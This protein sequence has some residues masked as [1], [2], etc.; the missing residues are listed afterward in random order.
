MAE[1]LKPRAAD[2]LLR[3]IIGSHHHHIIG[4]TIYLER[5]S[6][7][8]RIGPAKHPAT[9]YAAATLN[10]HTF[11]LNSESFSEGEGDEGSSDADRGAGTTE[12]GPDEDGYLHLITTAGVHP[13]DDDFFPSIPHGHLRKGEWGKL[14]AYLGWVYEDPSNRSRQSRRIKRNSIVALWND[15][16]FRDFAS[17]AI[18][19]HLNRFPKF[20]WRVASPRKLPRK[21]I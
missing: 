12:V 14:D 13:F 9:Q 16:T 5:L 18:D 15:N 7:L 17:D 4:D 8:A 10:E 1:H 19:Y 3:L 11:V 6:V 20:Q 21:R 2:D